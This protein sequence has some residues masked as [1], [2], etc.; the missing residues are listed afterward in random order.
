[1]KFKKGAWYSLEI[2]SA[3]DEILEV[4]ESIIEAL[5]Q[6]ALSETDVFAVRL[7]LDEALA[8]AIKHGN[9]AD[10][11][12]KVAIR[13]R[14]EDSSITITVRDEGSGF[15]FRNVPDPT[16]DENLELPCGRGLLLMRS[17]M[18]SVTFS[19]SGNE[20]TMVKSRGGASCA[21]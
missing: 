4:E 18:D 2:P 16:T 8:N 14:I 12:K 6:T 19:P 21:R 1:M 15:D 9:Q 7:A 13:F 5:S 20:V 17:Y 10:A 3:S 11:C